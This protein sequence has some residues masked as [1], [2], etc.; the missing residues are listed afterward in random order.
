MNWTGA[1]LSPGGYHA[2]DD[3]AHLSGAMGA[4]V[5]ENDDVIGQKHRQQDLGDISEEHDQIEV[6]L[7]HEHGFQAIE[8]ECAD[9]R[10]VASAI[11]SDARSQ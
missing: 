9:D 5:V 4:Q 2:L 1:K 10:L 3:V 6:A 7:Q 11:H 8:G